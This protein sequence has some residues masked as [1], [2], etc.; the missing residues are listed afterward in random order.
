MKTVKTFVL[1][2]LTLL[3]QITSSQ[4]WT[5]IAAGEYH[6]LAIKSDGTLWAWGNND[7]GQLGDV[8]QSIKVFLHKWGLKQI[9]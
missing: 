2:V 1:L 8:L 4:C 9:G 7:Y 3:S 6:T 5:A